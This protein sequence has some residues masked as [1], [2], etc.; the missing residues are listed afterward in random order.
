MHNEALPVL[1]FMTPKAF[2][3]WL[4]A[5]KENQDGLWLR[6]YKKDSKKKTVTYAEALDEALCYGWIDGQKKSYDAESFLQ[7]FTPRRAKSVWSKRNREHVARLTAARQMT[8]RGLAEVTRAK[9]DGRWDN[10]YDP[11]STMQVPA[12]F[13]AELKKYPDAYAFFS[14]LNKANLY[15]IAFR[16]QTAKKQETHDRRVHVLLAMLKARKR[17][18]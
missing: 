7:K 15:A 16:L 3:N 2:R 13:I 5:N 17:V 14:T 8:P 9:A 18:H 12:F 6:I 1:S 10:A 4:H 11:A